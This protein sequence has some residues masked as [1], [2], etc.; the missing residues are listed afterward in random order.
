MSFPPKFR[1]EMQA[2]QDY[3]RA[4]SDLDSVEVGIGHD[5]EVMRKH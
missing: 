3:V 4:K 1:Q 5:L 2:Y